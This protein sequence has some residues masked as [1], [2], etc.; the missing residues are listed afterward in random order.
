MSKT[1][2]NLIKVSN[3]EE[4]EQV[5][6]INSFLGNWKELV[7]EYV[8][9]TKETLVALKPDELIDSEYD[10]IKEF[11]KTYDLNNFLRF[12][13]HMNLDERYHC[14]CEHD[15]CGHLHHISIVST[16]SKKLDL[17]LIKTDLSYNY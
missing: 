11:F 1:N 14:G 2:T 16:Y 17:I 3:L 13:K 9:E 4:D 8:P 7:L 6:V 15:C 10:N 12:I 5:Q